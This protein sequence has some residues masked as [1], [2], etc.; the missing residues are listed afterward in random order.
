MR[1][2]PLLLVAVAVYAQ[3]AKLPSFEEYEV[4]QLFRGGAVQVH[5]TGKFARQFRSQ[6]ENAAGKGVNFAGKFTV[7]QWGCGSECIQM[8][9]INQQTGAVYRG[10]FRVL[11]FSARPFVFADRSTNAKPEWFEPISFR[12]SSRL[13]I[14]RGCPEEVNKNCATLYYE[15]ESEKFRLI[16]KIPV[17]PAPSE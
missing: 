4:S 10:P 13:L 14:V 17:A 12:P 9:V 6:I 5:L 15:W 16:R 7:A 11:D 8:A 3:K 2:L 1:H